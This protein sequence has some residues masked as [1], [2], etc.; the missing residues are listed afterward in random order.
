[1]PSLMSSRPKPGRAPASPPGRS[2]PL[3]CASVGATSE[4]LLLKQRDQPERP[5]G[6]TMKIEIRALLF[7][8]QDHGVHRERSACRDPRRQEPEKTHRDN[9]TRQHKRIPRSRLI[10]HERKNPARQNTK[11]QPRRG[12]P[13]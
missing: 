1:M 13:G 8:Q 11:D 5:A 6:I 9:S 10:D 2:A 3:R 12:T 7:A 4:G